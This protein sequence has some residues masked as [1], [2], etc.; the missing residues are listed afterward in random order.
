MKNTFQWF[1]FENQKLLFNKM[2]LKIFSYIIQRCMTSCRPLQKI[3]DI[4][5]LKKRHFIASPCLLKYLGGIR[6]CPNKTSQNTCSFFITEWYSFLYVIV[7]LTGVLHNEKT[8][9]HSIIPP[10]NNMIGNIMAPHDHKNALLMAAFNCSIDS[11]M[12]WKNGLS[13]VCL[14]HR[15]QDKNDRRSKDDIVKRIFLNEN[16]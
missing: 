3:C 7:K 5:H 14:S 15:G 12:C 4:K 2:H 11:C 1:L 10:I 13:F 16:V 9:L 6:S 8:S